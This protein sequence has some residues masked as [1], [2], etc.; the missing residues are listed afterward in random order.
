[1]QGK[2]LKIGLLGDVLVQPFGRLYKLIPEIQCEIYYHE[3]DQHFQVL[4]SETDL[5][6]LILHTYSDFFYKNGQNDTALSI[7]AEYCEAIDS[8]C[9]KNDV[10][11]IVN[12]SIYPHIRMVG[13]DYLKNLDTHAKINKKLFQ[14]S[15]KNNKVLVADLTSPII[16]IGSDRA[17]SIR[18]HLVMRMPYTG[19]VIPMIIE[20]YARIIREAL[21]PRKKA[22]ILDADNTLWGGIVGEDGVDGIQLDQNYPGAIYRIF[23]K[24]LLSLKESGILLAM[25]SKNNGSD[26]LEVFDKQ[27]MPLKL[28]DFSAVRI[29][30]MPKSENIL[31]ILKEL[32]IGEDSLVFI[33]DN[34]FEL[35]EVKHAIPSIS[36]YQFDARVPANSIYLLQN[37]KD[38][39]TW[40]AT[41]EDRERASLYKQEAERNNLQ[42]AS[43]TVKD[44]LLSLSIHLE[45]GCNRKSQISRITQLI[46][47]T[48]QF[49]LTTQRYNSIEVEELMQHAKVYDFRV[50][51]RFGDMGIVGVAIIKDEE[52]DTFLM[53]C[54]ALGRR[55]ESTML[56][57]ICDSSVN[58]R[59][60]AKY[61]KSAKNLMTSNFYSEN[62]FVL[63]NDDGLVK[64][65]EYSFTPEIEIPISIE[66]IF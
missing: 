45:V 15:L 64:N 33:D 17:I 46:N 34:I 8:F 6:I 55:V 39:S 41:S 37:I 14:L 36:V 58:S 48:N 10:I 66:R 44:Y 21:L 27:N 57:Y 19:N 26:V 23:Q 7:A 9:S 61:I 1:M 24:Q 12:T 2:K 11:V 65:Y 56:K 3:I 16:K 30:W 59:L 22:I 28:S 38:I 31:S 5:D 53:S 32:N 4:L 18:N 29:N 54:R 62:G 63:M 51:D 47:K 13:L 35:E 40:S 49:N 25:V 42:Q 60:V 52:I 43:R 50:I 20:E